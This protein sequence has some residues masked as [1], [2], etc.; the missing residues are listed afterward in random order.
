MRQTIAGNKTQTV[1]RENSVL[2]KLDAQKVMF[3]PGNLK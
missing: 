3:S 2:F 1:H